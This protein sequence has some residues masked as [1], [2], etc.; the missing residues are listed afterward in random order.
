MRIIE[1]VALLTAMVAS[2][3]SNAAEVSGLI[4]SIQSYPGH[5]GLLVRL[6]DP[7]RNY[8]NCAGTAW[9]IFPDEST[10]ATFVQSLILTAYAKRERI[11]FTTAG[12]YQNYSQI[13]AVTFTAN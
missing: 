1:T 7:V 4:Q 9:Y 2:T 5:T 13:V 6:N 11:S 3:T 8:D 12:C 10:R